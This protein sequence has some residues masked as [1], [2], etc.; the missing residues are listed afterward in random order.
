MERVL[1]IELCILEAA[2][3]LIVALARSAANMSHEGGA[4]QRLNK[5]IWPDR[6]LYYVGINAVTCGTSILGRGGKAAY[7]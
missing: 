1:C 2:S 6:Y 5:V 3:V 7:L 4:K